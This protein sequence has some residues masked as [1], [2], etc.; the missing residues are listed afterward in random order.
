VL[1]QSSRRHRRECINFPRGFARLDESWCFQY[2]V[3]SERAPMKILF[4]SPEGLPFSKTGGLAD[5]VEG[6]PKALVELGHEVAVV[7]PRYRGTKPAKILVPSFTVP[8]GD[9]LRFPAIAD[10]TVIS[11]VRYYFVDD[12]DYF[13]RDKLYGTEAGDYPDNGERFAEFSRAA[14]EVAKHVLRP[15][16]IHCHDWQAGLVPVI[17]RSQHAGDP[18]LRNVPVV[19]TVHNLGYHGMF[20]RDILARTGLPESLFHVEALEFY[21]KVNYLKGGLMYADYLTT[22]SRKYAQEIQTTEY[23]HGLEGVLRARADRLVGILNGVDYA[24]WSPATD[25]LIA[26]NYS[27]EDLSG[28][29]ACKKDLLERFG[30]PSANLDR[31]VVG[32]VS[33]FAAQKGF[34]LI[35]EAAEDL[36]AEELFIVAL[37][38]GDSEYEQL[39]RALA[40]R[41]PQKFAARIAY[42]NALAHKIEAGA[43]IF[44]MPSRYEPCGLNQIYSLAYGTVPVVRAT[45]GLDDTIQHFNPAT[46]KGTGFKFSEYSGAALL[47]CLREALRVF[48]NQ[49]SWQKLQLNGMA[50]DFSW[51]ASAAEYVKVYQAATKARIP[52]AAATSK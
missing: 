10:G 15:E 31:P 20:P 16:V 7:L 36:L 22:V 13:D 4:I 50:Q 51:K 41:Y 38:T 23:G 39:F 52:R 34:D 3:A 27:A 14:I 43:D 8:M 48:K 18:L 26:A 33:R 30:L 47:G 24:A 49:K 46:G 19:L 40:E 35:A 1:S 9:R 6:L 21:G 32:I 45:G 42:D 37:G 2:R 12:A 17:L 11:G 44:L 28:K 29:R 5:V 25:K